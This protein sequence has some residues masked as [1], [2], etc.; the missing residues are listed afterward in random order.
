MFPKNVFLI[1]ILFPCLLWAQSS[2][3]DTTYIKVLNQKL[4]VKL[5]LSNSLQSFKNTDVNSTYEIEPN[6]KLHTKFGFNYRFISLLV[7]LPVETINNA[8]YNS[9]KGDSDITTLQINIFYHQWYHYLSYN[10]TKGFYLKNT[11]DYIPNWNSNNDD[12][13]QFPNLVY[14]SY[15]G[16]STYVFNPNFSLKALTNQTEKQKR[17]AGSF[18]PSFS[19][20]YYTINNS[21]AL[22]GSNSTQKSNNIELVLQ[23]GYTY[24][25]ML[26]K[27]TYLSAGASFGGGYKY[28]R[29][30]TNSKKG[31]YHTINN[32]TVLHGEGQMAAGYDNEH[33]FIGAKVSTKW[34]QYL[35][36]NTTSTLLNNTLSAR[37][38]FGYRFDP[39]KKIERYMIDKIMPA[40]GLKRKKHNVKKLD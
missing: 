16:V 15:S 25:H 36:R 29:L 1:F 6:Q 40:L 10:K 37:I 33:F 39:P 32:N 18:T 22:T 13:I 14:Q 35:H 19:Y 38:F 17:S 7:T 23:A 3:K 2:K 31:D 21:Q 12:Y 24:T 5:D 11:Q 30:L 28:S 4:T 27:N 26:N 8:F 9:R 20:R 34:S